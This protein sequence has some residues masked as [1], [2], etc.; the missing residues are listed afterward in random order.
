ME[1][2]TLLEILRSGFILSAIGFVTANL[3]GSLKECLYKTKAFVFTL[4]IP[5]PL[6][7]SDGRLQHVVLW[8]RMGT[9]WL[10]DLMSRDVRKHPVQKTEAEFLHKCFNMKKSPMRQIPAGLM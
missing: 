9:D 8:D 3:L 2:N 6:P 1:G 10:G 4:G 7:Y 5:F